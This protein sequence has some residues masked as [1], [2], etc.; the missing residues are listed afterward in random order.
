MVHQD[1]VHLVKDSQNNAW[2][3]KLIANGSTVNVKAVPF[4]WIMQVSQVFL[5]T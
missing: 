2:D 5:L 3:G 1:K 4:E